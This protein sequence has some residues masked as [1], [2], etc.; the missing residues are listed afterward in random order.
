MDLGKL[1]I[2]L[3]F[4]FVALSASA[5]A[6]DTD[7]D[8][9]TDAE[10]ITFGTDPNVNEDADG[11]R[12][13]D[14]V[15]T[16]TG[17]Y[18]DKYN[19]GTDPNNPDTDRDSIPDGLDVLPGRNPLKP[20]FQI[21]VGEGA[22]HVCVLADGELSCY[23]KS[24]DRYSYFDY[25]PGSV[26]NPTLFDAGFIDTCV[27][28]QGQLECWGN[29]IRYN[30]I[31]GN[32][33]QIGLGRSYLCA[34][35]SDGTVQCQDSDGDPVSVPALSNPQMLSTGE[36]H[37]CVLD[38]T[39]PVCWGSGVYGEDDPAP[40]LSNPTLIDAGF[41]RNCAIDDTGVVCWGRGPD[42]NTDLVNPF[43]VSQ[44]RYDT[45][46]I[47]DTGLVCWA[48][49]T[50]DPVVPELDNPVAI[51]GGVGF[52]CA[53]DDTGVVCWTTFG[54][55]FG[56]GYLIHQFDK[57][58][59]GLLDGDDAFPL[60][61]LN[62][63]ADTDGDGAPNE[64]DQSCLNA[65]MLADLDD[66]N[67]GIPDSVEDTNGNGIVDTDET[68]PL[69]AD[70]DNDGLA[71]GVED[72]NGN[73]IVDAG[74]SDPLLLDSDSDGVNDYDDHFP[75]DPTEA[76]DTDGDG[77][78]NVA[79][80]DD[81][82]DAIPDLLDTGAGRDPLVADRFIEV[83]NYQTCAMTDSGLVCWGEDDFVAP[84][85]SPKKVVPGDTHT[86]ALDGIEILSLED[87]EIVCWGENNEG[88]LDAPFAYE[89]SQLAVGG[90]QSC[91]L[92]QY[93]GFFCWGNS[94][95]INSWNGSLDL[96]NAIDMQ[97]GVTHGCIINQDK[98]VQCWGENWQGQLVVPE[99]T[100][101]SK[102]AVANGFN[103]AIDRFGLHCWGD[104]TFGQTDL[105]ALNNPHAVDVSDTH[106]CALDTNGVTCW[107]DNDFGQSDVPPLSNPVQINVS[108]DYS[109]ALDDT[110]VVCWGRRTVTGGLVPTHRLSFDADRDG[111][112]DSIDVYR[113]ISVGAYADIDGDGA[114]DACDQ[115]CQDLGMLADT[116]NDNDGIPDSVEDSNGNGVVDVGETDP[117]N[118]DSDGDGLS[119]GEED[120]NGNGLVDAGE[121]DPLNTDSDYDGTDD[122]DDWWPLDASRDM[123]TDR[124][125]ILNNVDT[126]DD[127]DTIPDEFDQQPSR[128]PLV[129][130][131]LLAA[132]EIH[133][134]AVDDSKQITCWGYIDPPPTVSNP[135]MLAGG[136][137]VNSACALDDTGVVCWG[138]SSAFA[139]Q[140]EL[141]APS[142]IAMASGYVCAIDN[143][144]V[145][146]WSSGSNDRNGITRPP[147]LSNPI[148]VAVGGGA[149]CAIDD[150]GLTCWGGEYNDYHNHANPPP[151]VNPTFVANNSYHS[152]AI[153]D[154]GAV[155]WGRQDW[156][157]SDAP[158][159]SN[160]TK[161]ALG[162][163][164]SCAIDDT[165]VVCW[166]SN[167][168]G[169]T[170]VPPLSNPVEIIAGR[171]HTC[172]LDDTGVVCWGI[173]TYGTYYGESD[174]PDLDFDKDQDGIQDDEDPYPLYPG[175]P[176]DTDGDGL[177]DMYET[178]TGVFV[179]ETDTGTDP[180]NPDSD[181]DSIPDKLDILPGRSPFRADYIVS[182]GYE[183]T[184]ILNEGQV[185]CSGS[186]VFGES[187]VP[188]L[189]NPV[190]VEAGKNNTCAIDDTGLVCWGRDTY[191]S[192]P[193]T[194]T[195]ISLHGHLC[196]LSDDGNVY[197]RGPINFFG[198]LTVPALV[199]P[200]MVS[201][202]AFHSCA[203]DDTGV[204]CWGRND[205]GQTDV[206]VLTNPVYVDASESRTCALD[207]SGLV[208]WGKSWSGVSGAQDVPVLSNVQ[209][210]TE[211]YDNGCGIDDAGVSCWGSGLSELDGRI[212]DGPPPLTNPVSVDTGR[213]HACALDDTGV[214][215]WGGNIHGQLITSPIDKDRDGV[216]DT[217]D[218]YP[219]VAINGL[220]DN[221]GDG[222]PDSCDQTCLDAG[223]A[224]DPDDDNDGVP[225]S[226]EDMNA[227]GVV[228][229]GET[230][231]FNADS[232]GDG[233]I[234]GKEDLNANGIVDAGESNPLAVD[235]DGDTVADSA[236]AFPLD[237]AEW[238]DTDHDLIGNNEDT[239]DDGD[240]I[241]D[242]LDQA[243]GRDPL[244]ADWQISS[245]E[246]HN[247]V[248]ADNG[249]SC[250]GRN[251]F[252]QTNVP[253]LVNPVA[254]S[255]GFDHTCAID[256]S[257]VQCWGSDASGQSSVPA[258]IN[259]TVI[260]SGRYH[261]CAIDDTGV[262][263]WGS[264]NYGAI[265][266]IPALQ[267]P[268]KVVAGGLHAS[269]A[270]DDT[271]VVCWGYDAYGQ[272]RTPELHNPVELAVGYA[273]FCALDDSGVVCWGSDTYG[274][275][276]V[277]TLSN[278]I[279][280]DINAYHGCA[281]DDSGV[282]CWG[283]DI[284]GSTMPPALDNPVA[285][286]LGVWHSCALDNSG[287]VC[288]GSDNYSQT[289]VPVSTI[290][291]DKD[292]DG[293]NDSEEDVNGNGIVDVGETD[294]LLL[295]TD[296]DGI[297]DGDE[298]AN[299]TDPL[300]QYDPVPEN[301][302]I[303]TVDGASVGDLLLLQ[304][305]LIGNLVFVQWQ[306]ESCDLN[307]DGSIDAQDVLLLQKSISSP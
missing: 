118:A 59:D 146:C 38:D 68:D 269:C 179:S 153:D 25:V 145:V 305:H 125:G 234:D 139:R 71:D 202:G 160:P 121:T 161:L 64:C 111:V 264:D 274:E 158:P 50:L 104:N 299:G 17:I 276:S 5:L 199:N 79:D 220:A 18:I 254:V 29:N 286:S 129:P 303:D 12:L 51:D 123:D 185:I 218:V 291:F 162:K 27:V 242:Y 124:D 28:D 2:L 215:C 24:A 23:A 255:V 1:R 192:V 280:V 172:A 107:G 205:T 20:D 271:G 26:T 246:D 212:L 62:G 43:A 117:L 69:N 197:C 89:T 140:P 279:A 188:P 141:M 265:S 239:D 82:N 306:T 169:Q 30:P 270:L 120:A 164:H 102:L 224:A 147:V 76:V 222:A 251:D 6:V 100:D 86:C 143:G 150:N 134:C 85:V 241:P 84:L 184:C 152:C 195:Q 219:M 96:S 133:T 258:L 168:A 56:P 284:G 294:P 226:V 144:Q 14:I 273:A 19:A 166:G 165:G 105:P 194:P 35:I 297:S 248:L 106:A 198:Q 49:T 249:V 163:H 177:P 229:A 58:Q 268:T 65:G 272:T 156:G 73:G 97:L 232:D 3:L 167:N 287:V 170:D 282:V 236:D 131:W 190:A 182:A 53:I 113:D 240:T 233:L 54:N 300:N 157:M 8:G 15:E 301:C 99:L 216:L 32:I 193:G 7:G 261:S 83:G 189:S 88:Q 48:T 136:N 149:A 292:R 137:G 66:D 260:S 250:W 90:E 127:G 207:D 293:L 155:C 91:A 290:E 307:A 87:Y 227:N 253:A 60:I 266:S 63:R 210:F 285:I 256:D 283:G 180:N 80:L 278:P 154:S 275:T 196:A 98:Q 295:D 132:G 74:E 302:D 259:P 72:V 228:D 243:P 41:Y 109:C 31:A 201:A 288:W 238:L 130:D 119:D 13:H 39:G 78:G 231:P 181:G 183:H 37:S 187:T 44:S 135:R 61:A 171:N 221:D 277:P 126:D 34:L 262:V 200:R 122:G 263:C 289:S 114:P 101:V 128:D 298:L 103:C 94:T 21:S 191:A 223:M 257:G 77:I 55:T 175:Q 46:A 204:V 47:D 57:D 247:C 296:G 75:A 92:D 225:D 206:P 9:L 235:S 108:S 52:Y 244:I 208:C 176:L 10:E 211:D 245:Y 142:Y 174:V 4:V 178:N 267:N 148:M 93:N 16:N 112:D 304:Q 115:A 116:D 70:S 36:T 42:S 237:A 217:I 186:N 159:L 151:L 203:L 252:G 138:T 281:I 40:A 214:V 173:E 213:Y 45:C 11:D 81:D 33:E 22:G 230:D 95:P 67:D 209:M 110:G